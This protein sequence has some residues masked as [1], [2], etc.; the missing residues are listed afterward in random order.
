MVNI[1]TKLYDSSFAQSEVKVKD[2]KT[3]PKTP[4]KVG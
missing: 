4:A 1:I 2:L 3:R